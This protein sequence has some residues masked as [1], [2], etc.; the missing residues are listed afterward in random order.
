MHIKSLSWAFSL[1]GV[2]FNANF[3]DLRV[4]TATREKTGGKGDVGALEW[5]NDAD[6]LE[7]AGS[8]HS[9]RLRRYMWPE[10]MWAILSLWAC[11]A[12]FLSL[13]WM[14][15]GCQYTVEPHWGQQKLDIHFNNLF[16]GPPA[17]LRVHI[18]CFTA[19]TCYIEHR[20]MCS[21]YRL[22]R[23]AQQKWL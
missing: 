1:H 16:R 15:F 14:G 22:M 6:K 19:F 23:R 2:A 21:L 7:Y 11:V 13:W 20:T 18:C 5:W 4:T 8:I 10:L 17:I 9:L 12:F 3:K